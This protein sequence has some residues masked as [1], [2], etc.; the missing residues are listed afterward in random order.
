VTNL[1]RPAER[2]VAFTTQRGTAEQW[3]REG[4]GAIKRE[5]D[6]RQMRHRWKRLPDKRSST[7][8]SGGTW[9]R[10]SFISGQLPAQVMTIIAK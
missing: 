1:A 7:K 3:I 2:V 10:A 6:E 9:P 8:I 4:K 5:G